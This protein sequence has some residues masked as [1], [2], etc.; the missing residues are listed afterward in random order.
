MVAPSPG[1]IDPARGPASVALKVSKETRSKA[2]HEVNIYARAPALSSRVRPNN[3]LHS[4][5]ICLFLE[6][7]DSQSLNWAL[8]VHSFR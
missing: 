3:W 1:A 6:L 7:R 8:E 4:P 5:K 2:L